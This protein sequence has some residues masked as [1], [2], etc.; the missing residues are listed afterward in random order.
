MDKNF[1]IVT[2]VVPAYNHEDY[3][4]DCITSIL[5]EDYP[6]MEVI[7]INDGSTDSTE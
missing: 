5:D 7:V 2:V 6:N 4:L 1:P 3:V